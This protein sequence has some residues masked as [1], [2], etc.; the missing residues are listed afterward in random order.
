MLHV[1][2]VCV[3]VCVCVR[4][5]MRVCLSQPLPLP[6][7]YRTEE[8]KPWVLPVVRE[9]E[10]RMAADE[11][12][13]KEYLLQDGMAALREAAVRLVL[14]SGS[15]AL[16]QNRVRGREGRG[17]DFFGSPSSCS[18]SVWGGRCLSS[19]LL[20]CTV[21]GDIVESHCY[22]VTTGELIL[23]SIGHVAE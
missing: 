19:Q 15:R 23:M 4:A 22:V 17:G 3:C 9:V 8:G 20:L 7:A 10:Q 2:C 14:G 12:L 21:W 6:P 18:Q 1:H 16:V 13:D 5:Y 11:T